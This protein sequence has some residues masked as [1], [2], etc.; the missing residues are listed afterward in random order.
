MTT[1][2]RIYNR[3]VYRDETRNMTIMMK[4]MHNSASY[5]ASAHIT[6]SATSPDNN[7]IILF[8]ARNGITSDTARKRISDRVERIV[9]GD[10]KQGDMGLQGIFGPASSIV[11]ND[12]FAT[13]NSACE[14]ILN[15][16]YSGRKSVN[17]Y[18]IE[19]EDEEWRILGLLAEDINCIYGTPGSG[20][21]YL[22]A[23]WGQ[24]IQ[25]GIDI[26]GLR[27]MPGNV[28]YLDYET[29]ASKMAKRFKRADAGLDITYNPSILPI[30]YRYCETALPQMEEA[31]M[32]MLSACW[33]CRIHMDS[34]PNDVLV[35]EHPEDRV[36]FLIVDSLA[37]A[38][39]GNPRDDDQ[40]NQFFQT[41]RA[42][43]LPS[44]VVHHTNRQDEY[45]GSGY[46][47]ANVRNLWRLRAAKEDGQPR[48]S[49]QLQQ[50]KENDGAGTNQL[51][52]L[53][54]FDGDPIDPESVKLVPQNASLV[55]ELRKHARLWQQLVWTLEETKQHR[56][57]IDEMPSGLNMDKS[58][59]NTY[60]NYIWA[61]RNNTGKYK[62][63]ADNIFVS[64]DGEALVLKT[65]MGYESE[66][67]DPEV[68]EQMEQMEQIQ[69]EVNGHVPEEVIM[70][71]VMQVIPGLA[72]DT[73]RR[74]TL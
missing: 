7:E 20:K 29:R 39:G 47:L 30:E 6:I 3:F 58:R 33:R 40:V 28:L 18:E 61:L 4:Q 57:K 43:D 46:I 14:D 73:P 15:Y 53:L 42:T 35:C 31:L 9:R 62:N 51:G 21:S 11:T 68:A 70:E 49:L 10:E 60:R 67:L 25:Y 13:I 8:K 34:N 55:P 36:K 26:C 54:E 17:L 65:S 45:Y 44:L 48:L 50:E 69:P 64:A 19:D 5:D 63:L 74:V 71:E 41:L 32:E 66:Q 24:A 52:F 1:I 72:D 2:E 23:I 37:R 22:S 56:A 27:T 59:E 38:C 16:Y 12:W